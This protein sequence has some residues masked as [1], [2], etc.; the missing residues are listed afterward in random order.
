[1]EVKDSMGFML[2]SKLLIYKLKLQIIKDADIGI[3]LFVF[4]KR[5]AVI[6]KGK[7]QSGN[8]NHA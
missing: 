4:R 6:N 8:K 3:S 1:M 2:Y 5:N 7:N